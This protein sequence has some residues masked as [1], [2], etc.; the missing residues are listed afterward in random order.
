MGEAACGMARGGSRGVSMKPGR[1]FLRTFRE[2]RVA[3]NR[4]PRTEL[5]RSITDSFSGEQ[6]EEN[7]AR[8]AAMARVICAS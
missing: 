7:G 6:V 5:T 1:V 4:K 2:L 3:R 8:L